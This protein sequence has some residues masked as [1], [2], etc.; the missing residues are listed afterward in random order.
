MTDLT[1]LLRE[2]MQAL[3]P[4]RQQQLLDF[5]EFLVWRM[6][7]KA[8]PLVELTTRDAQDDATSGSAAGS[9]SSDPEIPGPEA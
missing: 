4:E 2:K 5:A 8:S 6:A 3:P 7:A 9:Q 1:D